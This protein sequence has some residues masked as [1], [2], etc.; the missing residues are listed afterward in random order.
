MI[1]KKLL[2]VTMAAILILTCGVT[3]A[4]EP[5]N[6]YQEGVINAT[7][8][9][10][11]TQPGQLRE[12]DTLILKEDND[13]AAWAEGMD[14]SMRLW[15]VGKT[16]TMALYGEPVV[17]LDR[18]DDWLKVAVVEHQ[19]SKNKLGYPGWVPAA[20]V[21]NNDVYLQEFNTLP[22]AL[23]FKKVTNIYSDPELTDK[24]KEV[25]YMTKLPLLEQN[26]VVSTVRLPLG[27]IGYISSNDVR[28]STELS[29][30]QKGIVDEAMQF[31]GLPY[32]WAGT[33]SYGFDCSGFTMRLYQSQGIQIPRDSS[34]QA[35]EGIAVAKRNLQP[36]DLV[37][38][39]NGGSRGN[40]RHVGLYIGNNMMIHSPNSSSVIRIDS[41]N[42]NPYKKEYWGAKRYVQ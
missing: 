40:V 12:Y 16:E 17:I 28:K 2:L 23:V 10:I 25:S 38:F 8:T 3:L 30:T 31:L 11:W 6:G 26:S 42:N 21:I 20:H 15:L 35:R 7:A 1:N 32:I 9:M 4:S 5:S 14:S 27:D 39:A 34:E 33:A 22:T 24:V 19:T 18:Q 41:I 36:G 29:F 13:P 37:F